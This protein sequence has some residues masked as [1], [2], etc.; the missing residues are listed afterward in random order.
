MSE[1]SSDGVSDEDIEAAREEVIEALARSAEMYGAKRSY[2]RLFG[3]LYF[4]EEPLSLDDLVEESGYAKS[5]VS[6]AM[7]TLERFYLVQRRSMPGEGKRAFFEAEEDFWYIFQQFL[8]QQVRREIQIMTRAL[9]AAEMVLEEA[10][11]EDA[12]RDL[13]QIRELQRMYDRSE[14]LVDIVTSERLERLASLIE[15]LGGSDR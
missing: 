10:D 14:T 13:E 6:T 8:D 11:G 12:Q 2:G 15:R 7:N 5:T 9:E 4:A 1:D 3:I